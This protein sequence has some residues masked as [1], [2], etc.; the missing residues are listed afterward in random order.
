MNKGILCRLEIRLS[1]K[2]RN[3]KE[4]LAWG[5]SRSLVT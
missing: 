4:P 1:F 5:G 3:R 2:E